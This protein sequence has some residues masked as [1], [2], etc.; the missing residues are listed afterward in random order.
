MK[1]PSEEWANAFR[2]ALNVNRRYAEA[3][4][5]WEGDILLRV[6]PASPEAPAPGIHLVLAHGT[7]SAAAFLA[8]SRSASSE[9]VFEATEEN[10]RKLLR[11]E[12]DPVSALLNRTIRV[13][14]NLPKL[15]RFT[16]AAKELVDTAGEIPTEI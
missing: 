4:Q 3:A 5:Q 11:R 9:F 15:M 8:D 7:C 6:A 13:Q 14:G 1:F 16:R 2:S 12:L 10:W